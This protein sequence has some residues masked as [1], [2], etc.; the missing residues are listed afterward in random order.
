MLQLI[1]GGVLAFNILDRI[2]GQWTVANSPW[3]ASFY[4]TL[5]QNTPMVWF[6]ISLFAWAIVAF[7]FHR[8]SSR[9]HYRKQGI[10]TVRVKVN[11]KVHLDK[12]QDFLKTKLQTNEERSYED[13]NDNVR[14]TYIDNMKKDWGGSKP[15][16]TM[17]YDERNCYLLSCTVEYNK[18]RAK[19]ALVFTSTELQEKIMDELNGMDVWDVKGED[20]SSEDLASD[21]RAAIEKL[22]E[23][24]ELLGNDEMEKK[25]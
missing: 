10:T 3:F 15:T 20:R 19:K 2:T 1:F 6:L 14:I 22:M 18:R 8:L 25:L 24:E 13:H 21:K 23:G 4:Q 17:E 16:I 7:L 9:N 12:L 11:R 5:I